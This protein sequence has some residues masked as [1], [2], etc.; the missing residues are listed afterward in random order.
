MDDF[1]ITAELIEGF[2]IPI[3]HIGGFGYELNAS[4]N[5]DMITQRKDPQD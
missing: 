5:I 1:F 3:H 2:G 4:P